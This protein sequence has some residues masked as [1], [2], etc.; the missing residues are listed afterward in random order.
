MLNCYSCTRGN[1][2][3]SIVFRLFPTILNSEL[4]ATKKIYNNGEINILKQ[5]TEEELKKTHVDTK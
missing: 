3:Q 2:S 1:M 4:L 5:G